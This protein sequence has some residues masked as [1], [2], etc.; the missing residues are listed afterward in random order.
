MEYGATQ[1]L[2]IS[3]SIVKQMSLSTIRNT[4]DAIV[5]LVTNSDDSYMRLEQDHVHVTGNIGVFIQRE[6][7][8]RVQ[9]LLIRDNA[10]GM[11]RPSLEKAIKFAEPASGIKE[12]KTVRGYFG[13]GLKEAIIA[14]GKGR[15]NT[16][17]NNIYDSAEVWWD[18]KNNQGQYR[19]LKQP[20][21]ASADIR[22]KIGIPVGNGT[23]VTVEIQ[24]PKI[25]CPDYKTFHHQLTCHYALRDINSSPERNVKLIFSDWK[26]VTT[27][28]QISYSPPDGEIIDSKSV[29]LDI[30]TFTDEIQVKVYK[31]EEQLESPR[32]NPYA[33][34]GFLIRTEGAILDLQLFKFDDNEAGLYFFGDVFCPKIVKML[35]ADEQGLVDTNRGGL[36]WKHPYCQKLRTSIEAILTPYIREKDKELEKKGA[37]EVSENTKKALNK[38]CDLLN[39][40]AKDEIELAKGIE[41]DTNIVELMIKPEY[42]NLEINESRLFSLY[43]P[44]DLWNLLD[45][46]EKLYLESNSPNIFVAQSEIAASALSLHPKYSEIFYGHFEVFG[47]M[48]GATGKVICKLGQYSAFAN[49]KV[50]PPQKATKKKTLSGKWHGLFSEIIPDETLKPLQRVKYDSDTGE[51]RVFINFPSVNLY[52]GSGLQGAE[53]LEGKIML[54][55]LVSEAFCRYIAIKRRELGKDP[56]FP[57]TEIDTFN[58]VIN[59]L[60]RKYLNHIHKAIAS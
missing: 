40:F 57:G 50:A 7:G 6:K 24:N 13:R 49:V 15:I 33:K 29:K 39:R 16:I 12:G 58:S 10:E 36:E 9:S 35:K 47:D 2:P 17:R 14:L 20:I 34:A 21:Q 27:T 25:T 60:Q 1:T 32:N 42:A 52:I 48:D 11:D 8:G 37:V 54:A 38:L 22:N 53:T 44:Q 41:T 23:V 51:I 45:S 56:Y 4:M 55:E 26:G 59:E 18:N 30:G 46:G 19:L 28:A 31:S 5:E 3:Q 43:I